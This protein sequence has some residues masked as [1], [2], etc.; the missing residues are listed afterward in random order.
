LHLIRN[1]ARTIDI[2]TFIWADDE[3]ARLVQYEL[4]QA[5]RRGVKI[6]VLVDYMGMSP[7]FNPTPGEGAEPIDI[8]VYRPPLTLAKSILPHHMLD[9]LLPR[10]A[11]QRM[12]LKTIIVD[13]AIGITGGRNFDNHYFNR[14]TSYNF[15]DRD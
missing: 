7:A 13:G 8:K 6:R 10:G 3:C 2:Q 11:N 4:E 1:A 9:S 12:H 15:K 14:S 5:A